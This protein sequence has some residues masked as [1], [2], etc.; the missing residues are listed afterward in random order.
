MSEALR[1]RGATPVVSPLVDLA[2]GDTASLRPALARLEQGEFDWITATS[3]AVVDVLAYENAVI[4]PS[5][6][7]AVVGESTAIA[8]EIA[9]YTVHRT[10]TGPENTAQALLEEWPEISTGTPVKVLTLRQNTAIPVLTEG[11]IARGHDVTPVVAFKVV[12][13]P[14]PR[15]I[16]EDV[17]SGRI[18]AIVISSQTIAEQVRS[19]FPN[20]PDSTVLACVGPQTRE[21][22]EAVGLHIQAVAGEYNIDSLMTSIFDTIE[23]TVE[24]D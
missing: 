13:V 16:R 10:P 11:L 22:A 8:F 20:I 5:T 6:K 24:H 19:Q 7:I 14:A 18:N 12:G 9:G 23:E 21:Q 4:P 3:P 15:R 2:A 1:E 17:E